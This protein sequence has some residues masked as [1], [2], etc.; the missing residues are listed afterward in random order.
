M[1][2]YHPEAE[3]FSPKN[4]KNY[5]ELAFRAGELPLQRTNLDMAT[6]T[7]GGP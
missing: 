2:H 1:D 4:K 7:D 3:R 6:Y 5:P